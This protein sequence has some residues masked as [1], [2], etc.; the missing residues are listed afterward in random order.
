MSFRNQR[1]KR[2]AARRNQIRYLTRFYCQVRSQSRDIFH[3]VISTESGISC[4]CEDYQSRGY[5]CKHIYAARISNAIV[6]KTHRRD[7]IVGSILDAY[8]RGGLGGKTKIATA[9]KMLPIIHVSRPRAVPEDFMRPESH[10]FLNEAGFDD[11]G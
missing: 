2:I 5:S 7:P 1:G 6:S 3:D 11:K 10:P 4:S 9:A 8:K